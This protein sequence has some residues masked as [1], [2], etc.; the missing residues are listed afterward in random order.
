MKDAALTTEDLEFLTKLADELRTQ[1][2]GT[3]AR[4]VLFQVLERRREWGMD[5]AYTDDVGLLIGDDEPDECVTVEEAKY[6]LLNVY[7]VE[8]DGLTNVR[9]LKD[10]EDYCDHNGIPVHRTGFRDTETL[11]NAFLT[12]SGFERHMELNR[13]NYRKGASSYIAHAFRNP[14]MQRLLEIVDKFATTT[15]KASTVPVE[16]AADA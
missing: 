6:F 11:S 8:P 7:E 10:V 3:T 14:E 2:R 12:R 4:P 9:S 1:D 15:E 16:A 5:P 13:H